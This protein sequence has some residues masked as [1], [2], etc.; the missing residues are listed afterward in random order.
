MKRLFKEQSID[1]GGYS[2]IYTI[3]VKPQITKPYL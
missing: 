3:D 2:D 1:L